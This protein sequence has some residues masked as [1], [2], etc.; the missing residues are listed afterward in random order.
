MKMKCFL[1]VQFYFNNWNK[2]Y[3]IDSTVHKSADLVTFTRKIFHGKFPQNFQVAVITIEMS[4]FLK[5]VIPSL[6][7]MVPYKN[8]S[9]DYHR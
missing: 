8:L 7:T 4:T 3:I 5:L 6:R 9:T 2:I 1:Y